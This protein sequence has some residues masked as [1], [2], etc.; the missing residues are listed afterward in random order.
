MPVNSTHLCYDESIDRWQTVRDVLAG[1]QALKKA[2]ERYIPRLTDMNDME[3][4]AY[5]NRGFFFNASARSIDG[6]LGIVFRKPASFR[7]GPKAQPNF[8]SIF[9]QIEN[10][11][12]LMGTKLSDYSKDVTSEVLSLGRCGSLVDWNEGEDKRAY[13][14]FYK[15]ENILNWRTMRIKGK[16][17]LTLVSLSEV[18]EID[19][20]EDPFDSVCVNTIRVLKL[21]PSGDTH[22]YQVEIWHEV[23]E[24][25]KKVWKLIQTLVPMR[26]GKSLD[27]IPFVFHGPRD[28]STEIEKS[29]IND[30]IDANLDH[31]RLVTD[32]RHGMHFTALPTAWVSGFDKKTE[33]RIGSTVAWVSDQVGAAAGFLEFKGQGLM[34][35]ERALDRQE[36]LLAVLG[37][38]LLE[39][40]KRVSES[41]EAL[42][43]RQ[44]GEFSIISSIGASISASLTDLI[45]WV[46]WWHSTEASPDDVT[47]DHA[48][49]KL[50]AD[51]ESNL[52]TAAELLALVYSWQSGAISRDTLHHNLNQ[53]ELLPPGRTLEE[54][55]SKIQADPPPPIPAALPASH[56]ALMPKIAA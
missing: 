46:Y 19:D 14:S 9:G 55:T 21:V 29:P 49:F 48:S 2:G 22:Q 28:S 42:S 23:A 5:V 16:V 17:R 4:Q 45:N 54:E 50:N 37:S 52:M 43:I 36:R 25:K 34:T 30:I 44:S 6:Y 33:L 40:H 31:Y 18:Q 10:D 15:A 32:Y 53:G 12:D 1:E 11:V 26:R 13:L 56:P 35:F 47:P 51:F 38:R 3:Y 8:T 20:P 39:S 41:A 24:G 27:R 7:L